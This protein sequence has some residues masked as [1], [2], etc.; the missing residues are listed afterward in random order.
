MLRRLTTKFILNGEVLYKR[1]HD[2]VLL[3]CVDAKEAELILKEIHP[4]ELI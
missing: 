1:N 4:L 3:R 2:M